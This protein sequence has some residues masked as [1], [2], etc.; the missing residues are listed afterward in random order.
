[1]KKLW[2]VAIPVLT[3]IA[4]AQKAPPIPSGLDALTD[5][6]RLPLLPEN[7][8]FH[9]VSSQDVTGLNNDGFDGAFNYL[10][11][12]NGNWVLLDTHGPG[13][14]TL[15]RVIHHDK[16]NGDLWI[17][18]RKGGADNTDRFPF[19]DLYSGRRAPFLSPLVGDEDTVHG[20][21]WSVVPICSEDGIK[22][23]TD[24]PGLFLNIFYNDYAPGTPVTAYSPSMNVTPA[25]E[26]W[27]DVGQPLDR[28]PAQSI[29]REVT[30]PSYTTVPVWSASEP[31]TVTGICLQVPE[32]SHA[33]LRHLRIRAYWDD[34]NSPAIDSP[35]GPFFGTGYWPVPD[36]AGAA[37]RFGYTNRHGEGVRLGRIATRALP[38]GAD[39]EGFYNF[40]PMPFYRSARIELLNETG[41]PLEYVKVTV[42]IVSGAPEEGSGYFHA[43]WREENPTIPHRDYT[44][45]ETRGHG[46]FE[47]AVLVMSS[48]KFDPAMNHSPQRGFLEGDARFY[49]DDNRTFAN[50]STGTEEYFLWGFYDLARWD[51]VFSFAVNGYPVHDTDSEDHS[52]MY[53]FHLSELVPYYR[54][55]R[56]TIEHGGEG[57]GAYVSQPS[58]YSSTAFYYQ[59]DEPELVLT[60]KLVLQDPAS[61]ASHGYQPGKVVWQG[62]RDLPFEGDRQAL[63]TRAYI[64]DQKDGTQES[65]AESLNS[66]GDRSQGAIAFTASILPGNRGIKLRRMLDYAP[67][68][69]A[70]QELSER[71]HPLLVPAETARVFVDG[72]DVGDWITAPRHARLAWLEDDFEIPA[73]FTEGKS[74][75]KIRL[76]V[77]SPAPWS[78]FEYR[79]Y[80]YRARK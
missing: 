42:R 4:L 65:L 31:G 10:Y 77:L 39:R 30:I 44:V 43:Q 2:F 73:Q 11:T 50:A 48:V 5:F 9:S 19:P 67:P 8:W 60:D 32:M 51:S 62:C 55:F 71:P 15:F 41:E 6:S 13:C 37:P 16:W 25:I 72:K 80:C 22:I 1:M 45:L 14:V 68:N 18:T 47:G 7:A 35:I 40:F 74:Q 70:G 49:I 17:R 27:K 79:A 3:Q 61:R 57:D 76:E 29:D 33:L 21:S 36:P 12:Q 56:F 23:W 46:R 59:R 69:I 64:A 53:R 28:R 66:C 52:V 26:R 34:Q 24:K 38:V 54:S 78:A 63:Y 20:S 58:N 75:V